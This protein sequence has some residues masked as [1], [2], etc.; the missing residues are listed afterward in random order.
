MNVNT[1]VQKIRFMVITLISTIVIFNG[2]IIPEVCHCFFERE[3]SPSHVCAH[4]YHDYNNQKEVDHEKFNSARNKVF[5]SKLIHE[6]L[7]CIYIPL[8]VSINLEKYRLKTYKFCDNNLVQT[9]C[10]YF[11]NKEYFFYSSHNKINLFRNN[12]LKELSSIILI[13]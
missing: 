4:D 3:Q 6:S 7:N 5:F 12:K 8:Q 9:K 11:M 10:S 2:C 1:N 13:L